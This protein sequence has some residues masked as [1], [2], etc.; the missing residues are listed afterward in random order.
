MA[1][2]K[3]KLSEAKERQVA[4]VV[5]VVPPGTYRRSGP[6]SAKSAW[7]SVGGFVGGFGL[8][9]FTFSALASA[10]SIGTS[11]SF[12]GQLL[13]SVSVQAVATLATHKAIGTGFHG[14]GA[15]GWG[16]NTVLQL[17]SYLMDW[18]WPAWP[19]TGPTSGWQP[20]DAWGWNPSWAP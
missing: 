15:Y 3:E 7:W 20:M 2:E 9:G 18:T 4:Q 1:N 10:A 14:G 12:V 5:K 13:T 8:A 11:I 16:A 6:P 17:G 19:T